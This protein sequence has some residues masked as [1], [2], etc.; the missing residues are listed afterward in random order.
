[1]LRRSKRA[2][3][4]AVATLLVATACSSAAPAPTTAPVTAAPATAAPV[5]AAPV[6][7]APATAA[8]VTA[9]PAT[10]A[11]A[12]AAPSQPSTGGISDA[13]K[14]HTFSWGTFKLAQRI[15][16]K[17]ASGQALNIIVDNQGTA[18]PVFGAEQKIGTD[19]GCTNNKTGLKATCALK[20]PASTDQNAQLAELEAMLTADQVDCLG[21]ESTLPNAFVDIVNKYVDA[22]IPVFTQNTDV[23]S[24]KRFAFFALNERDSGKANGVTTANLVKSMGLTVDTIAMG[25]G[26]PDAPW[27][28]D[29]MGGFAEGFKTVYPNA[30]FAQTEKTGL[31]I[32]NPDYTIQEA[33]DQAGPYLQ[34]NPNVNF[35]FHTDQGV[36]GV[37]TVIDQQ[38]KTGKAWASG[39]NVSLPILDF[40]DKGV[41]LTT[42]NQGFDNQAE[43]AVNACLKYLSAGTVPAN[44]LAYLQPIII[45]KAGGTGQQSSAEARAHLQKVLATPGP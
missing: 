18:I 27:A 5:T 14:T 30:K 4:F 44:P 42:I 22:G 8:A 9:A 31:P 36:E 12:T 34:G 1:M 26:G 39:F 33:I 20:G 7:A 37:A 45:T 19:R 29:R 40:I 16:D 11:P 23:P 15:I 25:S 10:A 28:Q 17:A 21:I 35:F 24:S 13:A 32:G 38:G 43:A 3:G 6:T 41:I 2:I